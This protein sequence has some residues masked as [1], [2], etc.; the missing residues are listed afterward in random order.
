MLISVHLPK[1]AGISFLAS[2]A[3]QLQGEVLRDYADMPMNATAWARNTHALTQGA[4]NAVSGTRLAHLSCIHGHFMPLKY[5]YLKVQ[6]QKKFVVWLR[7]PVERLASHY[8]F[9]RRD[10]DPATAGKLR[11]LVVEEDWTL[12]RF[13]LGSELQNLYG[14]FLWSFPLERFDFIGLTEFYADDLQAFGRSVMGSELPSVNDNSNPEK[15]NDR[16]IE[17]E[18]LRNRIERHHAVDMQIYHRA[19]DIRTKRLENV[20]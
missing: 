20:S 5:R 1:T 16:Y 9:W 3:P 6:R 15:V 11:R 10:Y 12:E 14:K 8:Y 13:C 2:I 7:D 19:L 4:R 18:D 17:D